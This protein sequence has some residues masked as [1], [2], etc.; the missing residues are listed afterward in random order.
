MLSTHNRELKA[1]GSA[2]GV[3]WKVLDRGAPFTL[4]TGKCNLCTKE[5]FYFLRKPEMASLNLRQ[6][7]G[8]H[9]CHIAMSL[10]SNV[11]KVQLPG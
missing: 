7:V 2:F 6:E 9:C 8:N 3:K 5:K 11:G 1:R 10:H 4:V